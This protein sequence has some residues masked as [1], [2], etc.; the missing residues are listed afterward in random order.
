MKTKQAFARFL[1][2]VS[3]T[4]LLVFSGC[5]NPFNPPD[6]E[7]A[8][9]RPS[10]GTG[11]FSLNLEEVTLGRTILP[12]TPALS[13]FAAFKL[14]FISGGT[15]Q[16]E[17]VLAA[18][19]S[20][21]IPL[22]AG[23]YELHVTAYLDT[24]KAKPAAW[25]SVTNIVI[26]SGET[27][28]RSVELA[29]IDV[30][31]APT[32]QGTFK[33]TITFP[34]PAT[35]IT[36]NVKI[37]SIDGTGTVETEQIKTLVNGT[38]ASLNLNVG[39]YRVVFTLR[40]N[41]ADVGA[42][43]LEILHVYQNMESVF[44][45][46]FESSQLISYSIKVTNGDNSGAGSLRQAIND[47]LSG[48][49]ITVASDVG[50]ITLTNQLS[51]PST[52][53]F[54]L[55]GNGV[56]IQASSPWSSQST[57]VFYSSAVV[58]IRRVHF[59]GIPAVVIYSSG[60]ISLESCVFSNNTANT[61]Q[62]YSTGTMSIKGSTFYNNS[63]SS[64]VLVYEG[65]SSLTITG[66]L[67][68]GNTFS[69]ALMY[70]YSGSITSNGYNV[71]DVPLGAGSGRSGWTGNITDKVI[72]SL[73]IGTASF[74][75]ISGR[76]AQNVITTRPAGYPT[77]DFYGAPIPATNAAVGAV[78][79]LASG[80]TFDVSANNSDLGDAEITE[81]PALNAD[82]LYTAAGQVIVKATETG[83]GG[84]GFLHWRVNDGNNN[85]NK[86]ENPLTLS[87]TAHFKVVAV[88]GYTDPTV[89][90][91]LGSGFF[92]P[93]S[94]VDA[95]STVLGLNITS[96]QF[97]SLT[98][99]DYFYSE[100]QSISK[101]LY[102][103]FKDDFDFIFFV[104]DNE[105]KV[106]DD[107]VLK[108]L[109]FYGV[110]IGISNNIK[111]I[112]LGDYSYASNWG[113]SGKLISAMYFPFYDA[114]SG[115]PTLHELAHNWAAYIVPTYDVDN[116][117]FSGHWG[118]SNAGGQ[119]GGFR[120][121]RIVQENVG[122]VGRTKYQAS[123]YQDMSNGVFTYPGFGTYANYGNSLPYSDIELYLMGM[124][125]VQD[126]PTNFTLDVYS[127]NSI[128]NY[129]EFDDEGYF[130][131]TTKTSYTINDII[132]YNG[133]G[134]RVPDSSKSQKNFKVLTVVLIDDETSVGNHI[135]NIVK[136]LKWFSGPQSD[137]TYSNLY[138]FSK[139]TYGVGSLEVSG[140]RNSLK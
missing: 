11:F 58:T 14:E 42:E 54:T 27:T 89:E 132:A 99:D 68:Y 84:S 23:T 131:S 2:L 57:P 109:G 48:G 79:S 106:K 100:L 98:S 49:M 71:V 86:N 139:A 82:G 73:P 126:L 44:A 92:L 122:T 67:F 102:K 136:D 66:N 121:V 140:V 113:S 16:T 124:K 130:Y 6:S 7:P 103:K 43:R 97:D 96:A 95:G 85:V 4:L 29:A 46:T 108:S 35:G 72:N 70:N 25:G 117:N 28:A 114:I 77:V 33:W 128:D 20:N 24:G 135:P 31:K 10:L 115:G 137:T 22:S 125:S 15:V 55:E 138:N 90:A 38:S 1:L 88:F 129:D 80:Y 65:T 39:Y 94:S 13:S 8:G 56:T 76:G 40:D 3:I 26:N 30:S 36:G 52:K 32:G 5:E 61:Y 34:T 87:L 134:P 64:M 118:V 59:T 75:P 69:Y 53:N 110:N 45:Y 120:Y 47:V 78:Q 9:L 18:N 81:F 127:G 19:L 74:K 63:S 21:P 123:M 93:S 116:K 112:G 101:S 104:L 62:I 41:A 91:N 111:G 133:N 51:I 17:D 83:L 119:L 105:E 60:D 107:P 37:T 50:T 12:A